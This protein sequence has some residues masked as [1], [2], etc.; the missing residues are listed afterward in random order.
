MIWDYV[1]FEI[2]SH[3]GL[4]SLRLCHIR[5]YVAFGIQSSVLWG[6]V[7]RDTVVYHLYYIYS[8]NHMF[9]EIFFEVLSG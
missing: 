9:V 8:H 4:Y 3:S 1:S 2:M 7:V 6:N 5:D